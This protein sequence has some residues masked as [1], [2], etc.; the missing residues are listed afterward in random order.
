MVFECVSLKSVTK[1]IFQRTTIT[2][3][4]VFSFEKFI[5]ISSFSMKKVNVTQDHL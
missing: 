1:N 3:Q 2:T 4:E 5:N